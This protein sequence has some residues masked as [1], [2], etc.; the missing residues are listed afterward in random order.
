MSP[1]LGTVLAWAFLGL[2][3]LFLYAPLVPPAIRSF[4]G[5]PAKAGLF[6]N[7]AAIAEDARLMQALQTSLMVGLLVAVITPPLALLA[8]EAVRV[9]RAP[10][11]I[12]ALLLIPLFVPGISMGVATALFFQMLGVTPSLLTITTVHV[13]WALP[14]AFLVILTVMATFDQVYLEA[15]YMSGAGRLRAFF[16]VELPQIRHGILAASVFSLIISFN[17]TIRTAVVQGG[18]NTVQTYLWSQ[19]QQVGLGSNLFALMTLMIAV[20]LLL[21]ALLA[22]LDRH[23]RRLN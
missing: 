5:L 7:Y 1:R 22:L 13:L 20:T 19:Y 8:A 12:I 18:R 11:L 14:F 2:V 21:M 15:A 3:L 9:W 23:Q 4:A 16:E 17:E 6:L 10:R